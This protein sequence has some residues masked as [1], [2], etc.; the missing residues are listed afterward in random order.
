MGRHLGRTGKGQLHHG[1]IGC[2]NGSS[3]SVP[4]IRDLQCKGLLSG[5]QNLYPISGKEPVPLGCIAP[6]ILPAIHARYHVIIAD[7]AAGFVILT[8][9]GM[10]KEET[11]AVLPMADL[12]DLLQQPVRYLKPGRIL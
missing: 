2:F 5:R 11:G 12:I 7:V 3:L 4:Q 6:V 1:M 8:V 9:L 10:P